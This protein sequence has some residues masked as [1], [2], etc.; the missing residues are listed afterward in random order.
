[1]RVCIKMVLM[2]LFGF[3]FVSTHFCFSLMVIQE[4]LVLYSTN[5]K[6]R[7][8]SSVTSPF[9]GGLAMGQVMSYNIKTE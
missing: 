5:L 3:Y 9:W 1:M 4:I 2:P 7:L 8:T 6:R